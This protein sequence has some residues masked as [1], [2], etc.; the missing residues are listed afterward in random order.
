LISQPTAM[1][2]TLGLRQTIVF[3][4]IFARTEDPAKPLPASYRHAGSESYSS[5]K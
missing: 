2:V 4:P 3:S 1:R 5:H